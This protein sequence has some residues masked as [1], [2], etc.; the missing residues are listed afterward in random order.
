MIKLMK[1]EAPTPTPA[2]AKLLR[3]A[4]AVIRE[5]GYSATT[6]DDL[7]QK[8]GV[9]KGAFFHCFESKEALAIQAANYWSEIT[10]EFFAHADYQKQSDP[11]ARLKGY[12][13]LR[14]DILAGPISEFT[15]LVGTLVQETYRSNPEIR[16]AC[17]ASIFGH[18]QEIA[19]IIS[20]AKKLHAPQA[21]WSAQSLA[22]HTQAV[23][24]GAFILAKASDNVK[25][26]T[27][28]VEHLKT[29]IDLL[30]EKPVHPRRKK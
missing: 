16:Q 18:A 14:Q 13:Q 27:E 4:L 19:K 20:E 15:C 24:Q 2:K 30:F 29:Y 7:C 26:A 25:I 8:A 5:R 28:S 3:S 22:L 23:L 1:A 6:V 11:L 17:E 10:T 12:I 21:K 9:S